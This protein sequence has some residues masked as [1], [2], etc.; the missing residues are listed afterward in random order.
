MYE[1]DKI[2]SWLEQRVQKSKKNQ[3]I[4]RIIKR[5]I[6][7]IIIGFLIKEWIH[8]VPIQY[9]KYL[10]YKEFKQ[11]ISSNYIKNPET[12]NRWTYKIET[13]TGFS[14]IDWNLTAL[15]NAWAIWKVQY[16]CKKDEYKITCKVE[17]NEFY[18]FDEDTILI[19]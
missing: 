10:L 12:I 4:R 16:I 15:N 2:D 3:K 19:K 11:E 14:Q 18:N 5:I 17:K 13:T 1:E 6:R 9:N 8:S 7:I